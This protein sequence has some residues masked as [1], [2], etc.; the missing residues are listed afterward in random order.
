MFILFIVRKTVKYS[1]IFLTLTLFKWSDH[2]FK[3]SF[4]I[5]YLD[6]TIIK[7]ERLAA[8]NNFT[9][10]GGNLFPQKKKQTVEFHEVK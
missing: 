4:W 1:W 5:V 2:I 8:A 10:P 7:F 9:N 3:K 6:F